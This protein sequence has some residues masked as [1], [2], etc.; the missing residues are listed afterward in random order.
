MVGTDGG[1]VTLGPALAPA[2]VMGIH[3]NWLY[4]GFANSSNLSY[5]ARLQEPG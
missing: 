4:H 5:N 3:E 1:H 2:P